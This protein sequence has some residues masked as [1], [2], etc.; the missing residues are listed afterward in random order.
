MKD[1]LPSSPSH[2]V[3]ESIWLTTLEKQAGLEIA[4]VELARPSEGESE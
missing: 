4:E 3:V 1:K 2:F